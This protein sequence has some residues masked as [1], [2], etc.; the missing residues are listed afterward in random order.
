[1]EK[2]ILAYMVL[3]MALAVF[4]LG[5]TFSLKGKSGKKDQINEQLKTRCPIFQSQPTCPIMKGKVNV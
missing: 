1:M 5:L 3:H 2:I 4:H